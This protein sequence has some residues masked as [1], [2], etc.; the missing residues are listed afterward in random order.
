MHIGLHAI[1]LLHSTYLYCSNPV[2]WPKPQA[3]KLAF[4]FFF[5]YAPGS[6]IQNASDGGCCA[7]IVQRRQ[8]GQGIQ[9]ALEPLRQT[10]KH[11]LWLRGNRIIYADISVASQF[12]VYLAVWVTE[13]CFAM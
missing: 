9:L 4:L 1:G 3:A 7:A 5:S 6:N 10:L 12:P 13:P 11:L 8:E 2:G